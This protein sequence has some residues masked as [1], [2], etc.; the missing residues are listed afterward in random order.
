MRENPAGASRSKALRIQTAGAWHNLGAVAAS[1]DKS[2]VKTSSPATKSRP[3]GRQR[4]GLTK[5]G[6]VERHRRRKALNRRVELLG[7]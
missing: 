7:L 1:R 4:I 6:R 3:T 2:V 5:T